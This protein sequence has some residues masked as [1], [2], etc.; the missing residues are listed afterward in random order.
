MTKDEVFIVKVLAYK[1][2]EASWHT[3]E[4]RL[5][6]KYLSHRQPNVLDFGCMVEKFLSLRRKSQRE[7]ERERE[8]YT[9]VA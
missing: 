7:R 2:I 3:K 9:G 6:G 4:L 1:G 5:V 8:E